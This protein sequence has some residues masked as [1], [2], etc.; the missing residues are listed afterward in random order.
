MT[1]ADLPAVL[2][3]EAETWGAW[4]EARFLS[5]L[6]P[7]E[8]EDTSATSIGVVYESD[9]GEV[10]G[11]AVYRSGEED[12]W[13]QNL[14]AVNEWVRGSLCGYVSWAACPVVPALAGF[15]LP[16]RTIHWGRV[17]AA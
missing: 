15:E 8:W 4:D 1:R 16:R 6:R 12:V 14:A 13:V 3:I 5:E 17:Q 2:A 7:Y 9:G 10:L 11:F